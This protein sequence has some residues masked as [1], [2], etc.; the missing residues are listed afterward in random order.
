MS[1]SGC[2]QFSLR[3]RVSL[4][5]LPAARLLFVQYLFALAV[6]DACRDEGMLGPWGDRVRIKW[7]N[8]LYIVGEGGTDRVTK[9]A[10]ILVYTA[11]D[12]D[13][14]DIIIGTCHYSGPNSPLTC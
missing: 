4:A 14:V 11:F 9:V 10:G 5:H 2:L 13:N 12:G 8:D 3:L 7:P 6:T 1:P